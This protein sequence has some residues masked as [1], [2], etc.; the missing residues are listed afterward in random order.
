MVETS[1]LFGGIVVGL[2]IGLG[3]GYYY[4]V[5]SQPVHTTT[6]TQS[7]TTTQSN[8]VTTT[9]T[10]I[11]TLTTYSIPPTYS[12]RGSITHYS[13]VT[14]RLIGFTSPT[15]KFN[16][17]VSADTYQGNLTNSL[18]Y[19]V[20]LYYQYAGVGP[21]YSNGCGTFQQTVAWGSSTI[22]MNWNC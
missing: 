1:T 10:S 16:F 12:V 13:G 7:V 21:L 14:A 20:S 19:T 15:A 9:I 11:S 4:G 2:L 5:S 22:T 3:I 18:K 6:T 8:T 17:T